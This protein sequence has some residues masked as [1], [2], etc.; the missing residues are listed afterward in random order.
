MRS[1]N[2]EKLEIIRN[3][4]SSIIKKEI[5]RSIQSAEGNV[6]CFGASHVSACPDK[7]CFWRTECLRVQAGL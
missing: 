1:M 3:I 5:I 7:T 6:P 4:Q 2:E